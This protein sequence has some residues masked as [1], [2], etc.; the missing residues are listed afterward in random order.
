MLTTM[1][2]TLQSRTKEVAVDDANL[3]HVFPQNPDVSWG[4]TTDLEPLTWHLGNLT[5]LGTKL[6]RKAANADFHTKATK[7][8]TQSEIKMTKEIAQKHTAWSSAD[9]LSRA[10]SLFPLVLQIWR[11]P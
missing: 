8:Y 10:R 5:I 1:A 4:D 3:E 11:G 7:Y 6:N 2:N 9:I